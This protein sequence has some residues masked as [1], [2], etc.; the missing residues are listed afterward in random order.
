M[1]GW[2]RKLHIHVEP[3]YYVEYGMAQ[4]GALQIW[5]NARKDQAEAVASYRKA[6]ALGGTV[7]LP[8]LYETAGAAFAFDAGTLG[9]SVQLMEEAIESLKRD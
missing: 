3:F 8:E 9:A 6:L 4:L 1:T 5:S 7:A 2:H